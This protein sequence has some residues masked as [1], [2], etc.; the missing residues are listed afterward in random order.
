MPLVGQSSDDII[1]TQYAFRVMA[2]NEAGTSVWSDEI[3]V[4]ALCHNIKDFVLANQTEKEAVIVNLSALSANLGTITDGALGG[5]T[6]NFWDLSTFSDETGQHYKGKFRVGGTDQYILVEPVLGPGNIPTGEYTITFKVGNFEV[7][8]TA[9]SI[10][11]DLIVRESDSALDQTLITPNGTYYQH[12]ETADS[13]WTNK[14]A[15]HVNGTMTKQVF[16][17]DTLFITNQSMVQRRAEGYD[18]G[19]TYLSSASKVYHFDDDY[20]DQNQVDDLTFDGTY[21]RVGKENSSTSIDFT[22][23]ILAVAP[24]ASDGKSVYGQ[25]SLERA[26]GTTDKFTVDFWIQYIFAESQVLFSVGNQY[27]KI[28]LKVSPDEIFFEI[29][30]EDVSGI[31]FNEEIALDAPHDYVLVSPDKPWSAGYKYYEKVIVDGMEVYSLVSVTEADYPAMVAEGLYERTL[32][33]NTPKEAVSTLSHVGINDREDV[34]LKD[35]GEHGVEFLPNEWIHIGIVFDQGDASV[36]LNKEAVSFELYDSGTRACSMV[37]NA[38]KN[39]FILDELFVDGT[40]AEAEATFCEHT[41]NRIP[42]ANLPKSEDYFV[43]TVS[44]LENFKTNIFDT[45]LFKQKV[46]GIINEYHSS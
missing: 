36:F 28:E 15:S 16:S 8:S 44:D 24:Y 13:P 17:N 29:G 32:P 23:A 4:L 39:S 10:N 30:L 38:T 43:L 40:V 31:P 25:F 18:I 1:N 11:G 34:E 3:T 9:S 41:Q 35:I 19:N 26:I 22:P 5:N 46:L 7:S 37:L 45:D 21:T 14:A 2:Q 6:D 42:W 20:K 33:F 27:D 12:R